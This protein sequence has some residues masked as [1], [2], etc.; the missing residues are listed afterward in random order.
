MAILDELFD[1]NDVD[2][3]LKATH[4]ICKNK[5]NKYNFNEEDKKDVSQEILLKV[6]RALKRYN[7]EKATAATYFNKVINNGILSYISR[8]TNN[9]N[10]LFNNI[11]SI[12]DEYEEETENNGPSGVQVA[13]DSTEYDVVDMI[14]DFLNHCELT[15]DEKQI[16]KLR[17]KGYEFQEIAS[18]MDVSK[19]RVSQL[20]KRILQKYRGKVKRKIS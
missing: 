3:F 5:L 12:M 18:I 6:Y 17:Y 1:L 20:W 14:V 2:E 19:A 7:K 13:G 16:F 4:K 11:L 9:S 10:M 8:I 15:D